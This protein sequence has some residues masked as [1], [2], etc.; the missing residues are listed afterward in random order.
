M[1]WKG[2]ERKRLCRSLRHS[3]GICVE[4]PVNTTMNSIKTAGNVQLHFGGT[5][6]LSVTRHEILSSNV[7]KL[8]RE[9]ISADNL[10]TE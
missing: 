2:C 9:I 10:I 4:G 5:A 1:N 7:I 6:F 3:P 8:F